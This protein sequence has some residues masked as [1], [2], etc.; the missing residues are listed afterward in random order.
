[1][2]SP[3]LAVPP[4]PAVA[5]SPARR[6]LTGR[7][8][9]RPYTGQRASPSRALSAAEVD[10]FGRELDA[11]RQ[12]TRADLGQRDVDHI[13]SMIRLVR[14]SEAGGRALL[15][16]G[17]GPLTFALGV[18]ALA[19]AKILEN[20]EVGHNVMHGQYDWTGDPALDGQRYEWDIVCDADH[21]RHS[22]NYEHHTFTNILG[23][24]RDVGYAFLRVSAHQ[25]W[26]PLHLLQPVGA[27]LLALMF[28]W[29]VAL[30]DLHLDESFTGRQ[31]FA[32]LR[33]RARPFLRKAG[34]QL[35]KDYLAFPALALANAPRVAL[36][37]L[38]AN[39]LRNL[40]TFGIIFC[41]HFPEGVQLYDPAATTDERRG[42]WYLRQLHGS[43]NL[44]GSRAF[45][46]LTGHLSHQIEHHLFPDLPASR[47]PEL[48]PHVHAICA[49]YGQTY[50]AGSLATQLGSVVKQLLRNALPT[51]A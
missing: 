39:G 30:H 3:A 18:T 28:Q 36:G 40:W 7:T 46:V 24:D 50:N 49:R 44:T 19:A 34:W 21:W 23:R 41:G 6:P 10:A 47:Y 17:I 8:S 31:S 29:G 35:A 2:P 25:P 33:Q 51:A 9:R 43:A 26:R 15:H 37:N 5:D 16:L 11:L 48:A 38:L 32:R 42:D 1:M 4:T 14:Y 12:S 20:M 45:H 22:H 27:A 13:R